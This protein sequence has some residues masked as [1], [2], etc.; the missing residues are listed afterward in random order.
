MTESNV[1]HVRTSMTADSRECTAF[2]DVD[3]E[4]VVQERDDELPSRGLRLKVGPVRD[5]SL[6]CG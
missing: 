1:E 6:S 2:P 4:G 3:R 5:V